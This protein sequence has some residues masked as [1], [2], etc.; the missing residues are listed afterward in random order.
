VE[1]P[2][3]QQNSD[4]NQEQPQNEKCRKHEKKQNTYIGVRWARKDE[5]IDPEGD[6]RDSA[7]GRQNYADQADRVLTQVV[8]QSCPLAHRSPSH[9]SYSLSKGFSLAKNAGIPAW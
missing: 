5:V 4:G 1:L 9:I 8:E 2:S 7:A 3:V 6:E